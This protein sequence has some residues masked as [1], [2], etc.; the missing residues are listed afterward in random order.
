MEQFLKLKPSK[1][2]GK[3]DPETATIWVQE[4]EKASTLLEYTEEEKA[5]RGKVF[6]ISTIPNWTAFVETFN[7]KYFSETAQEQ[8]MAEFLQLCQNQM[9][10]DQ[11]EAEFARLSKFAPRMVEEPMDRARRFQDGLKPNLCSQLILLNLRDYNE[12][13]KR[14]QMVERDMT[15]RTATSRSQ[16]APAKDNRNFGNKP[17]T[18]N[19]R[20]VPPVRKNFRKLSYYSNVAC[21]SCERR[22]GNSPCPGGPGACFGSD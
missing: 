22:H 17:M 19:R 10:L 7:G 18:G 15:E 21:R 3:G 20:F 9:T 4:L 6:P 12:L 14:A 1:F 16:Y 13:Y 8:K 11:Y 2:N 5:T